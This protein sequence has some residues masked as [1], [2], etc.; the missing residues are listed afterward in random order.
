M[1][2]SKLRFALFCK[3]KLLSLLLLWTEEAHWSFECMYG[4][5]LTSLTRDHF[6]LFHEDWRQL[7]QFSDSTYGLS[8]DHHN[9][10]YYVPPR[11]TDKLHMELDSSSS[12]IIA[13]WRIPGLDL[14]ALLLCS[15][16]V[17]YMYLMPSFSLPM[18]LCNQ[19]LHH[20]WKP[21]S[22]SGKY[23]VSITMFPGTENGTMFYCSGVWVILNTVISTKS[24]A[25]N[26]CA[27]Y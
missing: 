2:S 11:V 4:L 23:G 18:M 7:P 26:T 25:N 13:G 21:D 9:M 15:L 6:G 3:S 22:A 1:V 17:I 24:G 8:D 19:C 12:M 20:C 14:C 10:Y 27:Y 5:L 16:R